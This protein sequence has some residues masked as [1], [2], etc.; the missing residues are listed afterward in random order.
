MNVGK[1]MQGYQYPTTI[2]ETKEEIPTTMSSSPLTQI[3]GLGALLSSGTQSESGWLNRIL[4]A[5]GSTTGLQ[6]TGNR[7]DPTWT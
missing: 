5:V 7:E 3:A 4:N 2:S 6:D 1:I